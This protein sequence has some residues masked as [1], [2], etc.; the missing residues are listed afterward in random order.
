MSLD[1]GV[2]VIA[3]N[4]EDVVGL[5]LDGLPLALGGLR[6]QVVVV[7]NASQDATVAAVRTR[8]VTVLESANVGYAAG[9]NLGVAALPSG[10]P[11]LVLNPDVLL[12]PGSIAPLLARLAEPRVGVVA[13]RVLDGDGRLTPSLRR[14]PTLLRALGLAFTGLPSLSEDIT[15]PDVYERPAVVGWA[16][17]AV[18]LVRRECHDAL[19]GWDDTYFLYSEETDF[20]LRARDQG[21]LTVYEPSSTAHHTGSHAGWN[22]RLY[23]M[24]ILN[25]VRLYGRRHRCPAAW[26]FFALALLREGELAIRGQ[27]QARAALGALLR[28]S[29]R[30]VELGLSGRLAPW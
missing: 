29:A 19:G 1:V 27:G 16:T 25:R 8:G 12:D 15:A 7:D 5:L 9:I 13:P 22:D 18:L 11:I 30:P 24:Q 10:I 3:Y 20:S 14:E 4:S 23:A 6:A 21:W 26:A 17:G 28:P 2:V